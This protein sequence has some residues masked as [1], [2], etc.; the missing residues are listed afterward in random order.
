MQFENIKTIGVLGS[1]VMGGGIA[2]VS[3]Q[4]GYTT[5]LFDPYPAALEKA[6]AYIEKFTQS[7]V[8]KGKLTP[9]ER[10]QILDNITYTADLEQVRAD[11]IIEAVIEKIEV[12]WDLF[13]RLEQFNAPDTLLLT[14]T[15]SLSVTQIASCLKAPERCGG[16][17][18]FNPAP[19]M[20][21]VEAIAGYQTSESTLNAIEAL[22][23]KMGK[24][25]ARVADIPGF[26]VNRTARHFYLESLRI[27]E[28]NIASIEEIDKILEATGFKM[29]PFKLMDL[30]GV[31]TNHQVTQSIYAG[32]FQA[33]RF[34]PSL[35]QQK[36]VEAGH[37]GRKSGKGF[38]TYQ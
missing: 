5:L 25:P 32:Y 36:K 2:L 15:S 35:M 30:I 13:Q 6:R 24:T 12:K 4:T 22:A 3:A 11:C 31:D 38:Y 37:W 20:K 26:I 34:R 8:D 1:G 9:L 14:N 33:P 27:A 21:L 10:A 23:L 16:M 28:E 19:L 18:F 29:G 7:S 17:H